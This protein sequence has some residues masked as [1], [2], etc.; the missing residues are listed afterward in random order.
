MNRKSAK[1]KFARKIKGHYIQSRYFSSHNEPDGI[2]NATHNT[3]VKL[4]C[5]G[6]FLFKKHK[7]YIGC[8]KIRGTT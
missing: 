4:T 6:I 3:F 5:K 7:T 2:E 1:K 8:P